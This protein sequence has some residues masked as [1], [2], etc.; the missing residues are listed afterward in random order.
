[1]SG[2]RTPTLEDLRQYSQKPGHAEIGNWLARKWGRPW[3]IYGT[4][5]A[6]RLGLSA[7]QVTGLATLA[8]LAGAG[9][10]ATGT[11][12]GF[13]AGVALLF[14]AFWLDHVDGQV[15]RW[16]GQ[17]SLDG[18]YLDYL[19][20]AAW[21]L[22]VGFALGYGLAARTGSLAWAGAGALIASGWALLGLHND[23]RYKAFFQRLKCDPG[24]YRV[25]SGA[26]GTPAPPPGWPRRGAGVITWPL[27]KI[28]EPHMVLA[29][30]AG[31]AA[32]AAAMPAAWIAAWEGYAL[33]I[34]AA[35]PPLALGRA[36]RSARRGST[37]AEFADWFRPVAP[38]GQGPGSPAPE[39]APPPAPPPGRS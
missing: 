30:L 10:I 8:S 25:D 24:S 36:I 14:L 2:G 29:A 9:G 5:L 22:A 17:A 27:L 38:P 37:E 39:E 32:L 16:R 4:W 7:N 6:V 15:A 18:V 34:A 35:A 33:V 23:G 20:H 1:M 11:A 31:L 28:C 12:L 26:G 3:A 21:S 19:M 13:V